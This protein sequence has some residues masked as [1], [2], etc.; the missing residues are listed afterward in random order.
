M[1]L[2]LPYDLTTRKKE[3][4]Q[5]ISKTESISPN[6]NTWFCLSAEAL[7]GSPKVSSGPCDFCWFCFF[8][9]QNWLATF[10]QTS[11]QIAVSKPLYSSCELAQSMILFYFTNIFLPPTT[12]VKPVH[13]INNNKK[14]MGA[15]KGEDQAWE[16]ASS[17][18]L[19][20]TPTCVP[21]RRKIQCI[22]SH[23]LFIIL[24]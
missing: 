22:V 18:Y 2:V 19:E 13:H 24:V 3:I 6:Y 15:F 17:T 23:I 11:R 21:D 5:L 1:N 10:Y 12:N 7:H 4:I 20:S 16:T 9:R 14:H 8:I